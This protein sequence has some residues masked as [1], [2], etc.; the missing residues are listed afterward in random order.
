MK[1]VEQRVWDYLQK[2]KTAATSPEI[3]KAIGASEHTVRRILGGMVS[4]DEKSRKTCRVT[5]TPRMA[6]MFAKDYAILA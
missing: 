5:G 3:A 2:R 1:T 6:Y 4:E